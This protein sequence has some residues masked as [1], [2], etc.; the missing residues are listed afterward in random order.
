MTEHVTDEVLDRFLIEDDGRRICTLVF[1]IVA[2][3]ALPFPQCA[4]GVRNFHDAF[5]RRFGSDVKWYATETMADEKPITP[6]VRTMVATWFGEG[7][8]PRRDYGLYLHAGA[9]D[10]DQRPPAFHMFSHSLPTKGKFLRMMLPVSLAADPSA[11]LDL[12]KEAVSDLPFVWGTV[13]FALYYNVK[14]QGDRLKSGTRTGP[15]LLRHP[16]VDSGNPLTTS[17]NALQGV[18][19]VNWLTILSSAL[20]DRCGGADAIQRRIGKHASVQPTGGGIIIQAGA[21]PRIG[22]VN[23]DDRLDAYEAV[24]AAIEP[25]MMPELPRLDGM[26][27]EQT[28]R[29]LRRFYE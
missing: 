7:A 25:V 3:T 8:R 18:K 23:R 29:W 4:Q 19:T 14:S 9:T 17:F 13:G 27:K 1:D 21:A 5:F 12:T 15:L 26:S 2:Y 22:D 28:S 6:K 11:A 24:A 10:D 16:G 20:A